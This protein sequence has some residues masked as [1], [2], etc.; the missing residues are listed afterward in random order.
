MDKIGFKKKN[1]HRLVISGFHG[2][3]TLNQRW[4]LG[5]VTSIISLQGVVSARS[6]A[7]VAL[8]KSLSLAPVELKLSQ[9]DRVQTKPAGNERGEKALK[10][11]Y[12]G[13]HSSHKIFIS[14]NVG[15]LL[16]SKDK[17]GFAC[18]ELSISSI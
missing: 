17:N 7:E 12:I 5:L 16:E 14:E 4:E 15:F 11:F 10:L 8:R 6:K 13:G 2:L 18:K 1:H 3:G 9:G